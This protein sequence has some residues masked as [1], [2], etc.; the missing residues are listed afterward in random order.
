MLGGAVAVW[1]GN[2]LHGL[3]GFDWFWAVVWG[4]PAGL[5]GLGLGAG[6]PLGRGVL[7]V[8]TGLVALVMWLVIVAWRVPPWTL[9]GLWM[10][11]LALVATATCIASERRDARAD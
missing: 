7:L 4:L 8:V 1:A 3:G 5:V 2:A 9:E 6:G 11:S 10:W